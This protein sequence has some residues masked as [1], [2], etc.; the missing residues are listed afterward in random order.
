MANNPNSPTG[1][2]D[3]SQ[4]EE[5][6]GLWQRV[7]EVQSRQPLSAEPTAL[8]FRLSNAYAK[9]KH[10]TFQRNDA[11]NGSRG[12]GSSPAQSECS[13]GSISSGSSGR[14]GGGTSGFI[15]VKLRNNTET[16]P[17]AYGRGTRNG[18]TPSAGRERTSR[19]MQV[20]LQ[21]PNSNST[22]PPSPSSAAAVAAGRGRAARSAPTSTAI[23]E[24]AADAP[25]KKP[26]KRKRRQSEKR[27]IQTYLVD[28]KDFSAE[29]QKLTG[30]RGVPSPAPAS[31]A[32][33]NPGPSSAPAMVVFSPQPEGPQPEL[34]K[35]KEVMVQPIHV[36]EEEAN[37]V[38]QPID[39]DPDT[40]SSVPEDL[41]KV[42]MTSEATGPPSP[43]PT[44]TVTDP[45]ADPPSPPASPESSS[46]NY[47]MGFVKFSFPFLEQQQQDHDAKYDESSGQLPG[48][49]DLPP[50]PESG[51]EKPM[52]YEKRAHDEGAS[53]ARAS[54][55]QEV[56]LELTN[57]TDG[58]QRESGTGSS[59]SAEPWSHRH[60]QGLDDDPDYQFECEPRYP[61]R[62]NLPWLV[63]TGP[64]W[65]LFGEDHEGS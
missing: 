36:E 63:E 53:S 45:V 39:V 35:A 31:I 59:M 11:I 32:P 15:A 51:Y 43:S 19:G 58:V 14:G 5:L 47:C 41:L 61:A 54:T 21:F 64:L 37:E 50:L 6:R 49:D 62:Y 1:K 65:P 28:F 46:L 25:V 13:E 22:M 60:R 9:C 33:P 3:L 34:E 10:K 4:A 23:G 20:G 42:P 56:A 2:Q 27:P 29:V 12:R 44:V 8:W 55:I 17:S 16:R 18:T 7:R 30:F 48:D 57:M 40:T 26:P 24:G 38:V 52:Q